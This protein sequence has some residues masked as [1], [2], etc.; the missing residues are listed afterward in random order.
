MFKL[1]RKRLPDFFT[2][3]SQLRALYAPIETNG[4]V[5]FRKWHEGSE[6]CLDR[7]QT[8]QSPKG[9]FF[10]QSENLVAF[11][12]SGK[13]ITIKDNR[14]KPEPFAVFGV[15]ACDAA[16]IG[17][18]DRVFL[19]EPVD[20][21]YQSRREEGLLITL[22]C[23]EP[24]ET[25]FCTVFGVDPVQESLL[26]DIN[27]GASQCASRGGAGFAE[28]SNAGFNACSGAG[29]DAGQDTGSGMSDGVSARSGFGGDIAAWLTEEALYLKAST[30]KGR[31]LLEEMKALLEKVEKADEKELSAYVEEAARNR[32][33]MPLRELNLE[34]FDGASLNEKFNSPQWQELSQACIGCGT[35]TFICPTCQCYD[36]KDYDT[37]NGVQRYRCWDSCMYSDFTRMAH[38]NPRTS[39]V[40]RFRQRFMHKLVYFPANNEGA[41]ACVGCGRCLARCPVSMNIVK[42][43]KSLGVSENV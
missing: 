14:E 41:Y 26:E 3:L 25:C 31:V 40:E 42:V 8:A 13:N 6:V 4:Q 1:D 30:E 29:Q 9:L 12:T 21:F 19:S 16:G 24:E 18:L 33:A 37:G 5:L 34:G 10:P 35:C 2:A 27:G 20:T 36:I 7:L 38:G 15:R 43:V 32:D 28:A 17:V 22:A 23:G 39:R 11:K